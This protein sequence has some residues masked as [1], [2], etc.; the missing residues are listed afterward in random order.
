MLILKNKL[1]TAFNIFVDNGFRGLS[2]LL[3]KKTFPSGNWF[4][5]WDQRVLLECSISK[6]S[7]LIPASTFKAKPISNHD[8][9]LLKGINDQSLVSINAAIN[10]QEVCWI[11]EDQGKLVSYVWVSKD[12][13]EVCSDTA[14]ILP[15]NAFNYWWR[16]IYINPAYRG[17]GKINQHLASWFHSLNTA[18][19]SS[20]FC[21]ISPDNIPSLI[22]HQRNGFEKKGK[23]KMFCLLGFRIYHYATPENSRI[24]YRFYPKNIYYASA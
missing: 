20:L 15:T 24:S 1:T 16:D 12:K 2:N 19:A 14:F 8:A 23:L 10:R 11:I 7:Q 22:S 9:R 13:F 3:L 17:T 5:S 4:L 18:Q 21:E 6:L